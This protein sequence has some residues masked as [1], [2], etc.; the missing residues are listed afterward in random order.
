[1]TELHVDL[2]RIPDLIQRFETDVA[3]FLPSGVQRILQFVEARD[4]F[5]SRRLQCCFRVEVAFAREVD[6]GKEQIADLIRN[7][8][9]RH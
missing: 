9:C 1:M 8:F 7:R 5:V 3:Q 2:H 4:E 6:H